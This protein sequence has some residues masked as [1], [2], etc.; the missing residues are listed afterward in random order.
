MRVLVTGGAGFIGSHMVDALLDRGYEVRI[1]DS[2]EKP[3]HQKGKPDY[4]PDEAEFLLGD[5][6]RKEDWERGLEGVDVVFHLA[7]YQDYLTDFSRFFHVNSVGTALLY[8]VI[9]E[10]Q[11]PVQKVVIASSQAVYGE[12]T[13]RCAEDR[14]LI[15]SLRIQ[16]GPAAELQGRYPFIRTKAVQL[17]THTPDIGR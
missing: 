3:V 13:Y 16:P 8:E 1:L 9:V 7:A 11:L 12:G 14:V 10:R 5:V 6:R 4:I 15:K 2:L 17:T